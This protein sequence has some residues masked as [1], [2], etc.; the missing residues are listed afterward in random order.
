MKINPGTVLLWAAV[1]LLAAN[2]CALAH[3]DVT[4]QQARDL[5]DSTHDL[6]VIDVR[7]PYEY[8]NTRGH[9]PGAL[10]YPWNSGVLQARYQ[11]LP[12]DGPI[13]VVCASGG[14]SNAAATF[15]D[16]NGFSMVYDMLRG[17]SAWLWETAPCKY[18]GGS[19]TPDAPYKIA[20][21]ANLIALGETPEDYD[22]HF[23]LT[24]DIDLDPNLPGRKVFD[25]AVIAPGTTSVWGRFAGTPFTGVFDGN[26]HA[27]LNLVING[28]DYLGLFGQLESG[29]EVRDVG[30]VN[31]KMIGS[32]RT[33]GGLVG[34]NYDGTIARCYST[35][36][37][38]GT[39]C[40]GGL[41]GVNGSVLTPG[42]SVTESYS[43]GTVDGGA[44]VG[45]LVGSNWGSITT[46]YST[47]IISATGGSIGGLV[48]CN[49]YGD[50]TC[51]YASCSI[52]V[53]HN[54]HRIG[55]LVGHNYGEITQCFASGSIVSEGDSTKLGGL[56]G[57]DAQAYYPVESC[58]W[59]VETSGLF[60]SDGGTGLTSAQ[61]QDPNI[62]ADAGWDFIRESDGPS[63][64]WAQPADKVHPVLWWQLPE[65]QLPALPSFSGGAG[66]ANDPYLI[67][68]PHELN[69]IG[70]NPRLMAAHF[71]L[72]ED[73][74]LT[75]AKFF[76]IGNRVFRFSGIF[77][78]NGHTISNFN[79]VSTNI[80][81]TG[82]FGYIDGLYA[83][84]KNLGLS[85]PNV[86]AV[87]EGYLHSIGSL[88]GHF[89][90]GTISACYVQDGS[91]LVSYK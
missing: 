76:M 55:G 30:V 3:T 12:I 25:E 74:D 43:D 34:H 21:A 28:E 75:D 35:G 62:L 91:V 22:K 27:I 86:V 88:V 36:A 82:L 53:G 68:A 46:S 67:S 19:G 48:G 39:S 16:S 49:S 8:C 15:L 71:K 64:I 23:I 31:V 59:D 40:V 90:N 4:A 14:R 11:E 54:S 63:D 33:V 9:I 1:S 24:A 83:E 38:S 6:I 66:D 17:M 79:H 2:S 89:E 42:A 56:V 20:T 80:S 60:E 73:I 84:V 18:S 65:S 81:H 41:V 69:S 32:G 87:T 7:E 47:G 37:I 13:L 72:I 85:D 5:I 10:N 44:C 51:C 77:D 70:Y 26:G 78:G 61:M 58:F 29:A 45:G 57:N 50:I 52:S